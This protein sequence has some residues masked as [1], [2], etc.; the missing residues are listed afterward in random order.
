MKLVLVGV[1]YKPPKLEYFDIGFFFIYNQQLCIPACCKN[2]VHI[3]IIV[4]AIVCE[5]QH[6]H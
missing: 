5:S 6:D 1:V 4:T 2:A 3:I